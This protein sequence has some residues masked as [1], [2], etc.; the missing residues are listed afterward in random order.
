MRRKF[1][2]QIFLISLT[3]ILSVVFFYEIFK[4]DK[5][6]VIFKTETTSKISDKNLIE[7]IQYFSQD[8]SGNTY[9]IQSKTGKIDKENPDIIYLVDVEAKINFDEN[10]EIRVFSDE[11]IY[12]INN[13]DTEFINN[14]KLLYE[15]SELNCKNILVKFS[16]NYAI[17]S[18]N[19]VYNNLFTK[20][21]ADQMEIDL[22]SRVTKTSMINKKDKIKI[23]HKN[24]GVN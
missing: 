3:L 9:L 11:A 24:N 19:I 21:Y 17:L 14:V 4:K 23:I 22:I 12:N 10:D 13:Y 5:D 18:G 20:L 8:V 2:V 1:Q 7:G 16:K 15:N 6:E